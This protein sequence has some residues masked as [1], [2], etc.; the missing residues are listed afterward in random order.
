MISEDMVVGIYNL[1]N[2]YFGIS[3]S[4]ILPNYPAGQVPPYLIANDHWEAMTP[5]QGM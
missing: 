1:L 5:V 3:M 4:I 2:L